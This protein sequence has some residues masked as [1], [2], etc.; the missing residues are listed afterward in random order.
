MTA[1]GLNTILPNVA[2]SL[3][4]TGFLFGAGTSYEAGYPIM[5]GLTAAVVNG[6]TADEREVMDEVL[7]ANHVTYD[8]ATTMPNIETMSDMVIAHHVNSGAPRFSDLE[9]RFRALIVDCLHG[10]AAVNL[11]HHCHFMEALARRAHGSVVTLRRGPPIHSVRYRAG[12]IDF[13]RGEDE[14]CPRFQLWTHLVTGAGT[15]GH[16]PRH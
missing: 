13:Q 1:I 10:V 16:G 7:A 8:P 3:H 5:T 2:T 11:D 15:I 14:S 12:W 9:K 4:G 6:L